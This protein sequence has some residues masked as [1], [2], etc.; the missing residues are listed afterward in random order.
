M[1][2]EDYGLD[3]SVCDVVLSYKLSKKLSQ[4][5]PGD[6]PPVFISNSRQLHAF[7]GQLQTDTVR[8]CV[9]V[10]EKVVLDSTRKGNKRARHDSDGT[11]SEL[12]DVLCQDDE[13][14]EDDET[15]F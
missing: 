6:T 5:L 7:L 3:N 11:D 9:E 10:K 8:L 15:R 13:D 2:Y 1:V 14:L 4:Q 12:E